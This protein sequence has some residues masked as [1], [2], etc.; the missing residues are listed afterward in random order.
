M[1]CSLL[2]FCVLRMHKKR[3]PKVP[4]LLLKNLTNCI[5][6]ITEDRRCA[7]RLEEL[8]TATWRQLED[9]TASR[10]APE[11][12]PLKWLQDESLA[13]CLDLKRRRLN[14]TFISFLPPFHAFFICLHAFFICLHVFF[15]CLLWGL[16]ASPP[17]RCC[18]AAT[19]RFSSSSVPV[20]C[21]ARW[22]PLEPVRADGSNCLFPAGINRC[23][24]FLSSFFLQTNVIAFSVSCCFYCFFPFKLCFFFFF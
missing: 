13:S 7:R 8:T 4:S 21:C 19:L 3:H 14:G 24:L 23:F 17:P 22:S 10:N 1:E 18:I 15:I 20:F 5:V 9:A 11:I 6:Q 2:G 12:C 16:L